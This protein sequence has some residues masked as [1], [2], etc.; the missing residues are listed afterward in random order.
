MREIGW[1]TAKCMNRRLNISCG[2]PKLY[3]N[4]LFLLKHNVLIVTLSLSQIQRKIASTDQRTV[5]ESQILTQNHGGLHRRTLLNRTEN[6]PKKKVPSRAES[7][8]AFYCTLLFPVPAFPTT[9]T[10]CRTASSSSSWTTCRQNG[11]S[12]VSFREFVIKQGT[13]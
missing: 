1:H 3:L 5:L 12:Q 8:Q 11:Q 9:K 13:N 7:S 4:L 10:E 6:R 2:K